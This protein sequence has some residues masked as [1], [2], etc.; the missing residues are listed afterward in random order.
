[1]SE[2]S[3]VSVRK[4]AIFWRGFWRSPDEARR[5]AEQ[6]EGVTDWFKPTAQRYAADL[7]RALKKLPQHESE[8][9]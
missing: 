7:R 4:G 6:F 1:M 5:L 8:P 3:P 9:A 2:R